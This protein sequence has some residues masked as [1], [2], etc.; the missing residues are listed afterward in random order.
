MC[1]FVVRS[2]SSENE[3]LDSLSSGIPVLL[4]AVTEAPTVFSPFGVNESD[5]GNDQQLC[6]LPVR[7]P[8]D[9]SLVS[10]L[11]YPF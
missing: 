10:H 7:Y 11:C 5:S 9:C 4:V 2:P 6:C 8:H 3:Y 1:L